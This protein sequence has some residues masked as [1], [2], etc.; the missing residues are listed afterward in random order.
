MKARRAIRPDAQPIDE[1]RIVTVPRYK[2]SYLSGD[3]WR[4]SAEVQFLRKGK[5][6]ETKNYSTVE[7]AVAFLGAD[8]HSLQGAYYGGYGNLCDQEGCSNEA[9]VTKK[10]LKEYCKS[11]HGEVPHHDVIRKFCNKHKHRGDCGLEDADANYV[12]YTET[13]E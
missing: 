3:E 4:I 12:D 6:I 7:Y 1:I 2:E 13:E 9:A 5:V 8:F 11:G 10:L